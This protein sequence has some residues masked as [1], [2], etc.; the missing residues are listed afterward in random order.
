MARR[1]VSLLS[2]VILSSVVP[3]RFLHSD[4]LSKVVVAK[5]RTMTIRPVGQKAA[6]HPVMT[7]GRAS[8]SVKTEG[9]LLGA[10][11]DGSRRAQQSDAI[12]Q[13]FDVRVHNI[14]RAC[15][16]QLEEQKALH[17]V[18]LAEQ[19]VELLKVRG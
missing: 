1:P 8:I 15:D 10:D 6:M 9:M 14:R 18:E 3:S 19:R 17:R 12:A 11:V 5:V 13:E 7:S 4:A 16:L 2:M